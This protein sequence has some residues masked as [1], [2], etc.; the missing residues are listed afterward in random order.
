MPETKHK[1]T[2]M[3]KENWETDLSN[4]FKFLFCGSISL[5]DTLALY[6]SKYIKYLRIAC[7]IPSLKCGTPTLLVS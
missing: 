1:I 3:T 7:R 4:T 5:R 2:K 6:Y